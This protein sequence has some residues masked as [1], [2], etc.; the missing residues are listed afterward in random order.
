M[1]NFIL[2]FGH[3]GPFWS[4]NNNFR[5]ELW[6]GDRC[7]ALGVDLSTMSTT[8][9]QNADLNT[10]M[11]KSYYVLETEGFF[12]CKLI[13]VRRTDGSPGGTDTLKC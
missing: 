4:V 3:R 6:L 10:K 13:G 7:P 8:P 2:C 11:L 1:V 9:N 12:V 5:T